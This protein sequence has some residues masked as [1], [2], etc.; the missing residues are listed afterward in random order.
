MRFLTLAI[1]TLVVSCSHSQKVKIEKKSEKCHSQLDQQITVGMQT[2]ER[3]KK[4]PPKRVGVVDIVLPANNKQYNDMNKMAILAVSVIQKDP[5]KNSIKKIKFTSQEGKL[6]FHLPSIFPRAA[7]QELLP[8]S[9]IAKAFGKYRQDIY[10][11]I[12][13]R[14]LFKPGKIVAEFQHGASKLELTQFP[15]KVDSS[16]DE[17]WKKEVENYNKLP[18][19]KLVIGLLEK[20]YC[21]GQ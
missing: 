7:I 17:K 14:F 15:L 1:F 10:L 13:V 4:Q 21:L 19:P 2:W 18:N 12:P 3:Q 11:F 5:K 9:K 8:E 6:D 20:Y 16:L